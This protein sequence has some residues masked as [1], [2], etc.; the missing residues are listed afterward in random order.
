MRGLDWGKLDFE[1]KTDPVNGRRGEP[2]DMV[3]GGEFLTSAQTAPCALTSALTFAYSVML[4][5]GAAPL[6]QRSSTDPGA[7][8][9]HLFF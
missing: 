1:R 8:S 4:P 3:A 2:G 9:D 5:E 7:P 6:D